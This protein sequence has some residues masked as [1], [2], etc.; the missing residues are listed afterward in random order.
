MATVPKKKT[1]QNKLYQ[2]GDDDDKDGGND[3]DDNDDD[4]SG[5]G[6]FTGTEGGGGCHTSP[7]PLHGGGMFWGCPPPSR[8]LSIH[9]GKF[10]AQNSTTKNMDIFW[11]EIGKISHEF[12]QKNHY[13]CCQD[14]L[15][16]ISTK[17][18]HRDTFFHCRCDVPTNFF[19]VLTFVH[20][21][22]S[23]NKNTEKKDRIK[24]DQGRQ[25]WFSNR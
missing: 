15:R 7:P 25:S 16:L 23:Q 13:Y 5:G 8:S 14:D 17:S 21:I 20:R 9:E 22:E 2:D 3:D 10:A 11:T 1:A 24:K 19:V 12:F 6:G 18:N 4:E